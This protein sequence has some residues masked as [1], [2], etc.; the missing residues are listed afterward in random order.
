M[1]ST[2]TNRRNKSQLSSRRWPTIPT[3]RDMDSHGSA[4]PTPS[5]ASGVTSRPAGAASVTRRRQAEPAIQPSGLKCA[6]PSW[7]V[8]DHATQEPLIHRSEA[9]GVALVLEGA[10][11]SYVPTLLLHLEEEPGEAGPAVVLRL[12]GTHVAC[13]MPGEATSAAL[14]MIGLVE[15]VSEG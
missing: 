12:D 10:G 7:C 13:L 8:E 5:P 6:C 3:V 14:R 4:T 15:Q 11:L 9:R 1:S 2:P